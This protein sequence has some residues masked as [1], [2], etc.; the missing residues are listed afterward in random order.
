MLQTCHRGYTCLNLNRFKTA[1]MFGTPV[2]QCVQ[3]EWPYSS[4]AAGGCTVWFPASQLYYRPFCSP[5]QRHVN[6][7]SNSDLL[8]VHL[9]SNLPCSYPQEIQVILWDCHNMLSSSSENLSSVILSSLSFCHFVCSIY[10]YELDT[11]QVSAVALV[12]SLP[13][14]AA[15]LLFKKLVCTPIL[16]LMFR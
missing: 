14:A 3:V 7:V 8:K 1:W 16:V 2:S 10:H 4:Q 6:I 13:L 5:G 9:L 11:S 12:A 15:L